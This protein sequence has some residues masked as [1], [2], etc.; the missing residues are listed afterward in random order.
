LVIL[1]KQEEKKNLDKIGGGGRVGTK[2]ISKQKTR[3]ELL[4]QLERELNQ[5][6]T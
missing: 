5:L 2:S 6:P 4:S 1:A 3:R